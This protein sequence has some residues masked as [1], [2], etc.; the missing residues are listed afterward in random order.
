MVHSRSEEAL[1]RRQ[2]QSEEAMC[3]RQVR[4]LIFSNSFQDRTVSETVS[5]S[6]RAEILRAVV[7]PPGVSI[8]VNNVPDVVKGEVLVDSRGQGSFQR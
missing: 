8:S 4:R 6:T 3:R 2:V 1:S 7:I 5:L